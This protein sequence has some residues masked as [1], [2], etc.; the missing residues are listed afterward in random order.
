MRCR[1]P[2]NPN[3]KLVIEDETKETRV[4]SVNKIVRGHLY[5]LNKIYVQGGPRFSIEPT[6]IKNSFFLR[7]SKNDQLVGLLQDCALDRSN[8]IE[9]IH[10]FSKLNLIPKDKESNS[11]SKS[12]DRD[13][14]E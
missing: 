5:T 14:T 3:M 12:N 7:H 11:T 1:C 13:K 6:L 9:K 8:E 4:F 2:L 10:Y